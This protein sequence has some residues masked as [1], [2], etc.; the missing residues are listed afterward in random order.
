MESNVNYSK[1]SGTYYNISL[2]HLQAAFYLMMLGHA[3]ALACFV[4]EIMWHSL[5][6]KVRETKSESLGHGQTYQSKYAKNN[7]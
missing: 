1:L 2:R 4:T 5:R 7:K 6:S 3:L